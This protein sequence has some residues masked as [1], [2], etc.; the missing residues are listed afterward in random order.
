[1]LET[2]SIFHLDISGKVSKESQLLNNS[3]K[4]VILFVF[5]LEISGKN[6]NYLIYINKKYI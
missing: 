1:M 4:F 2:F 6:F 5:Q 3:F